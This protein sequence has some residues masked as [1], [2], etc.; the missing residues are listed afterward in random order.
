[1]TKEEIEKIEDKI[2]MINKMVEKVNEME[3]E[4][5]QYKRKSISEM[6]QVVFGEDLTGISISDPDK[7]LMKDFPNVFAQGYIARNPKNHADMWYVAKDYF[8]DNLEPMSTN[9]PDLTTENA[10]L[11]EAL[12]KIL[13]APDP[14]NERESDSW[15]ETARDIA[16][17]ALTKT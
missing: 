14:Y 1:M 6:R 7:Q 12:E 3:N 13:K 2:K 17:Q 9:E 16:A 4:F 5:K 10:R 15:I 11:R 8:D